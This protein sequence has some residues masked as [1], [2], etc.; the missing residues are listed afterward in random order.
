MKKMSI[1]LRAT[2][3]LAPILI[4]SG[5]FSV[6]M[7]VSAVM[8]GMTNAETGEA[9]GATLGWKYISSGIEVL[10]IGVVVGAISAIGY[11]LGD[12]SNF[13]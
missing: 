4:V 7:G 5:V 10:I 12:Q 1:Y 11:S 3:V 9:M 8:G 13:G 6:L 2:R